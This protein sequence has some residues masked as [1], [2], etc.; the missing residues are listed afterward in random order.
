MVTWL[1]FAHRVILVL[2]VLVLHNDVLFFASAVQS[3]AGLLELESVSGSDG[4]VFAREASAEEAEEE[5]H[6]VGLRRRGRIQRRR[7]SAAAAVQPLRRS[8]DS[9]V[10]SRAAG[11]KDAL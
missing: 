8:E 9:T 5:A 3:V 10:E 1:A 6:R 4:R 2:D 11:C 7:R